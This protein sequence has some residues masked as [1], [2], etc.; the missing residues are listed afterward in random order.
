[1]VVGGHVEV[2]ETP[3]EAAVRE[4][5]EESG[6]QV[7]LLSYPMPALPV[8]YPHAPVAAPWWITEMMVPPDNHLD[9]PHVHVDHQYVALA[10]SLVPVTE[11]VHPFAWFSS[12]QL[13][14]LSMFEDTRLLAR[15]LFPQIGVI[16]AA[17]DHGDEA[18]LRA[19][20]PAVFVS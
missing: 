16:A 4:V 11:A 18:S 5:V 9:E 14:G 3:A 2:D 1:M 20:V 15:L 13:E 10:A 8:G 12:D 19:A 7:R 17:A 6:L